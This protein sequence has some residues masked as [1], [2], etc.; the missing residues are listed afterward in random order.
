M[1]AT[2]IRPV[3]EISE[4]ARAL[5]VSIDTLRRWERQG[6]IARAPRTA[7]GRR[8]F[9]PEDEATIRRAREERDAARAGRRSPCAAA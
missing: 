2:M 5:G 1:A 3:L 4:M 9:L 6:V 7:S 8:V